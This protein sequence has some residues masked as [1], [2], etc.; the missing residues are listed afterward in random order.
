MYLFP[1]NYF[2]NAFLEG[3][4]DHDQVHHN[5]TSIIHSNTRSTLNLN[6]TRTKIPTSSCVVL[7]HSGQTQVSLPAVLGQATATVSHYP[8]TT[9]D[10]RQ[11][12]TYQQKEKT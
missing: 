12:V 1:T 3:T 6:I 11:L 10:L 8:R 4:F 2:K 7:S 5:S 9:H